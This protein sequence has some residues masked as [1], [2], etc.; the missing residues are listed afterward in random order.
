MVGLVDRSN[1]DVVEAGS[2]ST[3]VLI[4]SSVS[5]ARQWRKLVDELAP[6]FRV[7]AVNLFGYGS[8]PQWPDDQKQSLQD[9]ADLVATLIE[10]ETGVNL[11]GH[12]FGGSVAMKVAEQMRDDVRRLIL[13]E[14]NPF[15]LLRDN[16]RHEAY[17]EACS[18]ASIVKTNGAADQWLLAAAEF[19]DYWG[20]S[21]T[22]KQTPEDRRMTFADALKPNFHEWDAVLGEQFELQNFDQSMPERTLVVYDPKTVRPIQEIVELLR[23]ATSWDFEAISDGGHMAPL[24]HPDVVNPIV[25]RYLT[26]SQ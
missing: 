19:A 21:G 8:T 13:L 6:S 17:E 1:I 22:W 10:G 14:P 23:G 16:D 7:L 2:G 18:L 4:H 5:G 20:G 11:V 26:S 15:G 3:T 25:L 12:S 24:T 9:Q